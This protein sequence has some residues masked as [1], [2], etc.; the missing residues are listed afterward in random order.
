MHLK[1]VRFANRSGTAF[2]EP[3]AAMPQPAP[4]PNRGPAAMGG[5]CAARSPSVARL[6]RKRFRRRRPRYL[7]SG[8]GMG[9]TVRQAVFRAAHPRFLGSRNKRRGRRGALALP[10]ADGAGAP[11]VG[12]RRRWVEQSVALPGA[13]GR[14]RERTNC[15]LALT[16]LGGAG[17]EIPLKCMLAQKAG[18]CLAKCP[19]GAFEA[20]A[21]PGWRKTATLRARARNRPSLGE[22]SL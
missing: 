21:P 13:A 18:P 10:G 16:S 12:P 11:S 19:Y 2:R 5:A 22:I 7:S 6:P 17:G 14:P 4:L 1:E 8:A 20:D 9:R 15:S 3:L